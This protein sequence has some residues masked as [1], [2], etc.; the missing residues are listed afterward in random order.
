MNEVNYILLT[1]LN[2]GLLKVHVSEVGNMSKT[3]IISRNYL[4]DLGGC[5]LFLNSLMLVKKN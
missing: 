2:L 3:S 4:K 1:R 5:K